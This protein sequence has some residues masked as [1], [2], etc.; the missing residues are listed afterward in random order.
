[1]TNLPRGET[2]IVDKGFIYLLNFVSDT[3]IGSEN[4]LA[5]KLDTASTMATC[6]LRISRQ[7]TDKNI[8]LTACDLKENYEGHI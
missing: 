6:F 5:N 2:F 7:I 4:T 1:M 3:L 8:K